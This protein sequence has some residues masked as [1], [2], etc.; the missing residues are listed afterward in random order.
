MLILKPPGRGN[1]APIQL[2]I[3]PVRRELPTLPLEWYV[4]QRVEIAGRVF[5]VARVLA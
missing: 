2:E 3:P 5:R 4:G 1:W